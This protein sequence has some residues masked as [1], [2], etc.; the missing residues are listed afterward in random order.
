MVLRLSQIAALTYAKNRGIINEK[1]TKI[2]FR[3]LSPIPLMNIP[4]REFY[5]SSPILSAL[6]KTVK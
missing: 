3:K 5:K 1:G 2:P 4:A 6:P